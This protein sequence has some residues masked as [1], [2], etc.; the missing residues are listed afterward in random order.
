MAVDNGA[1]ADRTGWRAIQILPGEGTDVVST[2][3]ATD[4]TD[5]LRVYPKDLLQS[6]SD[7]RTAAFEVDPGSGRVS[8]PDGPDGEGFTADRGAGGFA[9]LLTGGDTHGLLILLLLA[10]AFGWGA[11]HALSPGHGKSMVAGYLA[12]SRG[13]PRHAV[14]LGL[15]VTAT[16]TAA[17]FA[18]GLVTLA[19]S[20]YIVPE[21]LYPWLGVASGLL[22]VAIGIAVMRSRYRRWRAAARGRHPRRPRPLHTTT[23]TPMITATT[24]TRTATPRSG[25]GSCWGSGSPAASCRARPRSSC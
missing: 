20:Q 12:G 18:L 10:T 3:P 15:T 23:A 9:G 5:G 22:V 4:P 25:P 2:V 14:A 24:I 17:V 7:E 6:P 8:A 1:F 11:L 21:D 19:A 13:R 16:H